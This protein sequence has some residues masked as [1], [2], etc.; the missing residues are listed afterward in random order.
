MTFVE[1][2][3]SL[4]IILGYINVPFLSINEKYQS[5]YVYLLHSF[6]GR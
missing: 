2:S 3:I 1:L 5:F 4:G 6:T